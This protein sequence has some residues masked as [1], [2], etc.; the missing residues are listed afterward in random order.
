[1]MLSAK[2]AG[3]SVLVSTH[4]LDTAERLCD[5]I[6]IIDNG[7]KVAEGTMAELHKF[8][9][10]LA[11]T[12]ALVK[13]ALAEGKDPKSLNAK[14]LFKEWDSYGQGYMTQDRYL[15]ALIAEFTAKPAAPAGKSLMEPLHQALKEK[16]VEGVVAKYR[17]LKA[18]EPNAYAFNEGVL[19]TFGYYLMLN[20]KRTA[21]AIV[22]LKLNTEEYPKAFNPYDSLGDAYTRNGQPDL[23]ITSYQKALE[24]KPDFENSK[25]ELQKLLKEKEKSTPPPQ[26]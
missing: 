4:M 18:K 20:K 17:E 11:K 15:T 26:K 7:E 22:I 10:M 19:N 14:E 5:R 8:Q 3:C 25:T 23:A 1:M 21:D 6:L 2:D 9:D 24:I 16:G 12:S 13:K